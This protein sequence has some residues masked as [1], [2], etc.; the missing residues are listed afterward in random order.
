MEDLSRCIESI[1]KESTYDNY[2]IIVIENNSV[3]EEIEAYYKSLEKYS[4]VRVVRYEGEFNYSKINNFGAKHATGEYLL[5]LNNDTQVITMNWL[6]AMLMY[7]QRLM[8]GMSQIRQLSNWP[9]NWAG[10]WGKP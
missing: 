7:A 8:I 2:E 9:S 10:T 6:E 5:L 3:T 4:Q 1:I